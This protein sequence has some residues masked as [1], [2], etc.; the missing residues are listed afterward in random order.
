[1]RR[2]ALLFT[3]AIAT[4]ALLAIFFPSIMVNAADVATRVEGEDFDV[5]PTG[6]KVVTDATYYSPPD[7]QALKFTNDTA[8]AEETV[9][10]GSQGNVVLWARGGQPN[11]SPTLRVKVDNGAFSPYQTIINNKAP[12]A[13]TFDLNVSAGPH[14]IK[15]NAGNTGTQR[16][17]FVDFVTFP[18]SGSGGTDPGA[19]GDADDIPDIEDNCPDDYN[20]GQRDDDGDG[21]G[22]KCDDGSTTPTDTDR[23]GVP[24][25]D[26]QCDTEPGPAPSGCPTDPGA[27]GDADGI[28]DL[29]D[30]CPDDY[31]PGQRDDDDDGVGNKCDDGSTTPTDTDNDGV[32][33]SSDNCPNVYNPQ[34]ADGDGDGV[35]NAC[36]T[37]TPTGS[38]V[39]VGAGDISSGGSRDQ[40][41]GDLVRAQLNGGAWGVFTTGD[42]SYP[43]GTYQNYQVYNAAWGSFKAKTRP[44]FGNHDYYGSLSAQ[45][46]NQ[47][48]N[49]S[50]AVPVP[51]GFTNSNSYYLYDI[52]NTNWRG[53]VLNSASS[54]GPKDN[55]AP[56]CE[57][58]P[59][60]SP[61]MV[62]LNNALNT[63]KNTVLF[64]H[65]ARFSASTDHPTTQGAT[66][67]SKTFF[68][69]AHDNGADLVVQGHSHVYE[70]YDTRDKDGRKVTGGLTS[71][72]CGTGGNSSDGLQG[73]PSP[74]YDKAFTN[75]WGV[76]TL[77]LNTNNAEVRFLRAPDSTVTD[78][79]TVA[80][81]P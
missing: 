66:G 36:E 22:N 52:P 46:A 37:Q 6:T 61:Q 25:V 58:D 55:Q 19:D 56:S 44:A 81:R 7:Y 57:T 68:D 80:V 60:V 34:Q 39:L 20:P 32:P 73:S 26:D 13:Y 38:A 24:D 10:F 5:Q 49:E 1:M 18:P 3:A 76:C 29:E 42:N 64:W 28:P 51:G 15:V 59:V 4:V 2:I 43:D 12:V 48:W 53:I 8:I 17:P 78:S 72:V 69:E 74:T 45:G 33:D 35:G 77:T 67:C 71:I 23:D 40:E 21:V 62:F 16:Y 31:N 50:P 30:N 11:G 14:T 65:H 54:E 63:T 47:Y 70:R 27:D 41:T 9:T 79:A 75:A